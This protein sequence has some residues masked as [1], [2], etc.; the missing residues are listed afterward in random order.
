M[1]EML[2]HSII[3]RQYSIHN[4]PVILA[5]HRRFLMKITLAAVAALSLSVGAAF[6]SGAPVGFQGQDHG[7]YD[8][9]NSHSADNASSTKGG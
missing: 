3:V 8:A 7:Q 9:S 6:A 5:K 1:N 4:C 2:R